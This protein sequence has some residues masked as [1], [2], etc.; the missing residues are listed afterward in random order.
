MIPMTYY[1]KYQKYKYKYRLLKG[2][3]SEADTPCCGCLLW[4]EGKTRL[5]NR[6]KQAD[7]D[8]IAKDHMRNLTDSE[9]VS[10]KLIFR[11]NEIGV[12]CQG[13]PNCAILKK[14]ISGRSYSGVLPDERYLY[15]AVAS[16][17]HLGDQGG[18][19]TVDDSCCSL[20]RD[21]DIYIATEQYQGHATDIRVTNHSN[22]L[23]IAREEALSDG[24]VIS[25]GY[26][27]FTEDE[28]KIK[29]REI[30][31]NSGHYKPTIDMFICFIQYLYDKYPNCFHTNATYSEGWKVREGR[32]AGISENYFKKGISKN[33]QVIDLSRVED[34]VDDPEESVL[35]SIW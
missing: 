6:E 29:I 5:T 15:V 32:Q 13:S 3:A 25:A 16:E 8:K 17:N 30:N 28:D 4:G 21:I 24:G 33:P 2:G 31:C 35:E 18:G 10:N 23:G 11:C 19:A 1:D 9:L 34:V 27:T 14:T 22:I 20:T 26:I 7:R 12:D